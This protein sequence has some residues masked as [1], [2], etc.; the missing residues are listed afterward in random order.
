LKTPKTGKAGWPKCH[1]VHS[2]ENRTGQAWKEE[3]AYV[4][5]NEK[6]A[7]GKRSLGH[8]LCRCNAIVRID[9]H[10]Y[11]ACE[12]CGEIW[13]D[14]VKVSNLAPISNRAKKRLNDKLKYDCMHPIV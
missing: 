6:Y 5:D 2:P 4:F 11:A 3:E 8:S 9:K 1:E 7:V 13:N 12:V 10:G 14:G